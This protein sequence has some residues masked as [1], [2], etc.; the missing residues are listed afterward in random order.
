MNPIITLLL[1]TALIISPLTF[2]SEAGLKDVKV[3][4]NLF[5]Q[6]GYY[7]Q[8]A[9]DDFSIPGILTSSDAVHQEQGLQ[10]MHG[11]LG[12]LAIKDNV[13]AGKIILGSHHGDRVEIEELWLQPYIGNDWTLR[14]GRQLSPIGLYN[15]VHEHDWRFVDASLAQQAFLASQ[16]QDDSVQLTY[17]YG[18][19]DVTAWVGRG[20]NF[21]AQSDEENSTPAA[22]G[23]TYQWQYFTAQHT[24]RLV[25]SVAR[26][27]ASQRGAEQEQG[28]SHGNHTTSDIVFD[29]DTT[30]LSFGA[31]W[32][33]QSLAA[34]VEWMGQQVNADLADTQQIQSELEAFQYGLSSQLYWQQDSLEL[35]LR[36]DYLLSDNEVSN[37]NSSFNQALDADGLRP[38]RFSAVVNWLIT[39]EQVL[40]LQGNYEDINAESQTAFWLIYQAN[41]NW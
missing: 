31:Q 5:A 33:W 27:D 30:L 24:W 7:S 29:G 14:I 20:D 32:Q 23:M 18:M 28:H 39:P 8:S 12:M 21:P 41:M 6:L 36:Y 35:A 4:T 40:R 11:E 17:A 38:Q 13:L 34:E 19:H 9:D 26:F 10:F 25:G 1:T 22:Y 3:K 37:N 15:G 16:Y 2:A